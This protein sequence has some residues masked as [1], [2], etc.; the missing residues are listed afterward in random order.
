MTQARQVFKSPNKTPVSLRLLDRLNSSD[1]AVAAIGK[2]TDASRQ[3]ATGCANRQMADL[4]SLA[5]FAKVVAASSF[6]EAARRLKMPISTVSRRVADLED[7]LG[8]R[9]LER[10]TRNLR[11]T[12]IGAEIYQHAKLSAELGEAVHNIVSNQLSDVSGTLSLSAPPSL[13]DSLLA[14]L[15]G[16]FQSSYPD[17]RIRV[18]VTDRT[19]DHIAEGVDVAI[20]ANT[21]LKDSS[22]VARRI[23]RFRHLLVASPA[24]LAK[25]ASI[26][27]PRDLADHP[28]LAFLFWRTENSWTLVHQGTG[29]EETI[30]FTPY[31]AMNDFTGLSSLLLDG[32]GIGVIPPIVQSG[33]LKAGKLVEVLPEWHF[34][35]VDLC[36]VHLGN[37][38]I[39][40]PLRLFIEFASQMAPSLFPNLPT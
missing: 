30:N 29:G 36:L 35:A 39:S 21:F 4:N 11:L 37:R 34:P 12:E 9:L 3:R 24:Y 28:L 5:I 2:I 32:K 22:Q 6:S 15:I 8:T 19:I 13:S 14:P 27:H 26:E 10:S 7:Q 23:L 16:G 1:P 18:L 20:V 38:H 33:H 40:R 17:V 25:T 31:V